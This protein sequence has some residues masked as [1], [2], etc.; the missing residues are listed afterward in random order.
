MSETYCLWR[1]MQD[2]IGKASEWPRNIRRLF[3][4]KSLHYWERIQV[5]AFVWVNGLNPDVF[6]DWCFLRAMFVPGSD[7]HNHFIHLFNYFEEGR[8]YNLWAWNI[9]TS[10]Y[11]FLD[12]RIRIRDQ[13]RSQ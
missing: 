7:H 3:W 4:G 6:F 9:S 10:R 11:E 13:H 12:R 5:A 1:D 2:I 8:N